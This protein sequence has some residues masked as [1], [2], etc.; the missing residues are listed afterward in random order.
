M[1]TGTQKGA[2][3]QSQGMYAGKHI[4]EPLKTSLQYSVSMIYQ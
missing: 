4:C 2:V 3:M 1:S